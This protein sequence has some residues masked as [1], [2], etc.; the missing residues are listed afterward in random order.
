MIVLR[1]LSLL[2]GGLIL[3]APPLLVANGAKPEFFDGR[4]VLAAQAVALLA[5]AAFFYIG[6]LGERM[7]KSGAARALGALLLA[8]PFSGGLAVLLRTQDVDKLWLSGALV[9]LAAV[10]FVAFV[11]PVGGRGKHRPMRRREPREPV[12]PRLAKS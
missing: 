5:A 3:V 12:L 2:V 7:R 11:F 1:L 6:V 9:C 4:T 10:L 8:V